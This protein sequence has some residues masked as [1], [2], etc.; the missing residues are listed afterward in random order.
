[1]AGTK[2]AIL[3]GDGMADEPIPELGGRTALQAASTPNLDA[4]A[5][6]GIFGTA[7]TVPAGFP[8]GS[9]VANL[10]IF[11]YDP[12]LH[13]TGRAA[14]EAASMGVRLGP[15][16]VAF[17]CNL[18]TLGRR[19]GRETMEDFSAGHISTEE[20]RKVITKI[21]SALGD[22]EFQFFPGVSYRHLLVWRDGERA[23]AMKTTPPHD[24]SGKDTAPH[25]PKGEGS[26]VINGL[27]EKAK[28]IFA[29][30]EANRAN[31]IWLWGQGKAP[32]L[33][34]MTE[35]FGIRGSVISA[36]DLMKGIGIYAGLEVVEVPGATGYL[37]TNYSGK[38]EYALRELSAKDLAYVHVEA[39]DEAS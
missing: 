3:C 1:M 28:K 7:R 36:V 18:V 9:D 5:R 4:I 37:D 21:G 24:I 34:P 14:L 19:E 29:A 30:N 17:R 32:A 38:A 33:V 6:K 39:P 16:D 2:F 8:P 12:A 11:G 23:L 20:A 25:L 15:S 26:D 10:S 35:R 27:M 13:Y 22:G 31:A